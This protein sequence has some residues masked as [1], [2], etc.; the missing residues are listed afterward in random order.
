MIGAFADAEEDTTNQQATAFFNLTWWQIF[1]LVLGAAAI[2]GVG[3]WI[4]VQRARNRKKRTQM[5]DPLLP[6]SDPR[7]DERKASGVSEATID[8]LDSKWDRELIKKDKRQEGLSMHHRRYRDRDGRS[9]RRR[10]GGRDRG[11]DRHR[12]RE[13]R[14]QENHEDDGAH[15]SRRKKFRDSVFS[16]Y[17]SMKRAAVKQRYMEAKAR[18]KE[19]LRREALAKRKDEKKLHTKRDNGD[20]EDCASEENY[21]R[22]HQRASIGSE[23]G[24]IVAKKKK[25]RRFTKRPR[26]QDDASKGLKDSHDLSPTSMYSQRDTVYLS[27]PI[28]GQVRGPT[29]KPLLPAPKRQRGNVSYGGDSSTT[30]DVLSEYAVDEAD[31]AEDQRDYPQKSSHKELEKKIS[32]GSAGAG[33]INAAIWQTALQ[34]GRKAGLGA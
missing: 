7:T 10:Y 32:E 30:F 23:T 24:G 16:S 5:P 22:G 6:T 14:C 29:P 1:C 11:S 21:G 17:A 13:G 27:V 28:H 25:P 33:G 3:I 26:H 4:A 20:K 15:Q 19:E 9:D 12:N 8:S 2:L 18:L 34:W 31:E